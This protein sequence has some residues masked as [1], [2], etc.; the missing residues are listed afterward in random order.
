MI[1]VY[2]SAG[3][4]ESTSSCALSRT[5]PPELRSRGVRDRLPVDG[6]PDPPARDDDALRAAA[7]LDRLDGLPSSG[8]MRVTVPSP[9]F[10]TQTEP[11][12]TAIPAGCRPTGIVARHGPR[13]RVDADDGVVERV[14][15]PDAARADARSPI[16]L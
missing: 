9:L 5:V 1:W 2:A 16:G 3:S 7:D 6:H 8:S 13:A 14:G 12:P 10:A 4:M 11:A 15:H